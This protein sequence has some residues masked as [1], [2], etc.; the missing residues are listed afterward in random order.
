M[1]NTQIAISQNG[2][3]TLAT[4]GK[5]CERNIDI[6]VAVTSVGDD[7]PAY[8][9]TEADSL[10]LKVASAQGNRV[11][12]L[13]AI[14]DLHYGNG[15]YTN[16]ILHASQAL[17]YINKQITLDAF[18]VLGDYTDGYPI[19]NV[20]NAFGDCRKVNSL[21]SPME[22]V[23]NMR[24]QG[25]HDFYSGYANFVHYHI[26]AYSEGVTW[27]D[28]NG[29]Y[30]YR[31]FANKKLRI[32]CVNTTETNNDKIYVSDAQYNWFISALD[33]SAKSDASDWQILIL[34]HH[35]LDWYASTYVFAYILEA[36]KSGSSWSSGGVSCNFAGKNSATLIGNI[37]GHIHNLLTGYINKG[38]VVTPNPT[39]V[40]RV[41][42]PE[43]CVN[44]A[45]QYD[46]AWKEATSYN[47]TTNSAKDTSFVVYCIDLNAQ[48]IKAFCYG[49]GYD[50]EISYAPILPT[51]YNIINNLTNCTASGANTIVENGTA[52]ITIVANDEYELPDTINVSGASYTW[53]KSTG[54]VIL[55]NPISDVTITVIA[56]KIP[57]NYTN[58]IP[59]SINADGSQ[60][61]GTNGE[62][63]YKMGYRMNSNSTETEESAHVATLGVT[64]YIPIKTGDIVYLKNL[65]MH[66]TN[67]S[68]VYT[69]SYITLF[70]NDFSALI[71][72]KVPQISTNFE[73][74]FGDSFTVDAD[75]YVTSF[76]LVD[77]YGSFKNGGYLRISAPGM[78]NKSIITINEPI[79]ASNTIYKIVKDLTNC[80]ATGA[81]NIAANTTTS[82]VISANVNY[83]LPDS[84]VVSGASYT[85]DKSTGTIVLSNPTSDVIITVVAEVAELEPTPDN[86]LI[87][88]SI[89]ADGTPYNN[90]I[91]WKTNY[92]LNSSGAEVATDGIEVTGFMPV[93]RDDVIYLKGITIPYTGANNIYQYL[94]LYDSNF[95][96]ILS[97]QIASNVGN[98]GA[99]KYDEENNLIEV[100]VE[101]FLAYYD[102][103][104]AERAAVAYFRISAEEISNS[105]IITVNELIITNQ[106][107]LSINSDG[108]AYI[109][110]NGEKGYKTGYRLNSSGVET[111][112]TDWEV[113]GF[114]PFNRTDVFYFKNIQWC[115]GDSPNNDYIGLYDANF[116]KIT[117][118]KII[119]EWL[120][121]R[122]A[123]FYGI[124]LDADNN[125][126]SIDC[127]KWCIAGYGSL[128]NAQWDS[129]KYI[130]FSLY[131]VTNDSVITVNE[132]IGDMPDV[133]DAPIE[134]SYI[135]QVM[136]S[137]ENDG[138]TP[139][140]GGLRYKTNTRYNS[141]C[142][143]AEFDSIIS[144]YIPYNSNVKVIRIK[145]FTK[146]PTNNDYFYTFDENFQRYGKGTSV[147]NHF[148]NRYSQW[149]SNWPTATK[150][151]MGE[152]GV[153]MITL[154]LEELDKVSNTYPPIL[155]ESK[156]IRFNVIYAKPENFIIT[157]D[158]E[159]K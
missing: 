118:T 121:S 136:N 47:K 154:N 143:E 129:V 149:L 98:Y 45:N 26:Q 131:D 62:D 69:Y 120:V 35:P 113:T 100:N 139:Y 103:T 22:S 115:G 57:V 119:S 70:K 125:I 108:T 150:F 86:N 155:R 110:T 158:E 109:G 106:I 83:S 81:V 24:I 27:G 33:L 66:R 23:P 8:V 60:F 21:L 137:V 17:S 142:A 63:G 11:F 41:C 141:S 127:N 90:G 82:I 99:T 55:S 146:E 114:I 133:P 67:N 6:N 2:K 92:R 88:K 85:W 147:I 14:T 43:A 54:T 50:R 145:G 97:P 34:S 84:I 68:G 16:G 38:N 32:I 144:G 157:F 135:N 3:T 52:A 111:S 42:T 28:K 73:Y 71:S 95:G 29:G 116:T 126:I 75:G 80:T 46:G 40:L 105:S 12:T 128:V 44:R 159:I 65:Q 156:W 36:Y 140:N 102:T 56:T 101:Q 96:K 53:D 37:H 152:D 91:G 151:E 134:P 112:L 18:A 78:S 138:I 153:G 107:P 61:V 39:K 1:A 79:D 31:D 9:K 13:A 74:L 77:K 94:A 64:G 130:R 72:C 4:A 93:N 48:S 104:E 76:Q 124:T 10:A 51:M 132:P 19:D 89:N 25:N 59:L 5:Y 20:D 122:D 30:F 123:A 49:A 117:S 87:R 7:I 148:L 15:N 58:Q